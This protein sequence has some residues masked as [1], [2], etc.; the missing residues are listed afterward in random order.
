MGRGLYESEPVFR[1]EVDRCCELLRPHLGL[2]LRELLFPASGERGGGGR[3]AAPDRAHAAGPVR[4]RVR[5]GHASGCSGGSARRRCSATASASTWPPAW[6]ASSR[7]ADA[8]ALVAA[9]GRLMQRLPGGRDARRAA[10]RGRGG[11]A[12]AAASCRSPPS[13]RPSLCVVA[14]PAAAIEA[15]RERLGGAG[16]RRPPAAHLARLPLRDDGPDPGAVRRAGAQGHAC[17]R[18]ALPYLSNVTGTWIRPEEATDPGLL[19]RH[20]R[21]TVRF[22]DGAAEL[23]REPDRVFLEVGPGNALT[24]LARQHPAR[25]PAHAGA[26]VAAPPARGRGRRR[27]SCSTP[28]A[29]SGS[30]APRS[31]GAASTPTSGGGGCRCRPTPSSASATGSSRA[32][33]AGPREGRGRRRRDLAAWF[34]APGWKRTAP[35]AARP[36]RE[37]AGAWLVFLD[38]HGLGAAAG[39]APGGPGAAGDRRAGRGPLRRRRGARLHR[40][41]LERRRLR[42]CCS[43][44]SPPASVR[45]GTVLH[46]WNVTAEGAG[47][48]LPGADR[49]LERGFFSLIFLAQALGRRNLPSRCGSW[50]S[51]PACSA[52]TGEEPLQPHKAALLGPCRVIP[53]EY[54]DLAC[55]SLDVLL[56]RGRGR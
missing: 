8:L 32:K 55:R 47:A 39:R 11:A 7:C 36:P 19:G 35:R 34:Y 48:S 29:G 53:R 10:P 16:D 26:A 22:A 42:R 20:I 44:S 23:L 2:D 4:R 38:D 1:G 6:P 5:A 18:R 43:R 45:P 54:P 13:T 40:R 30:P 9:R 49:A 24:T 3:A 21:G 51:R 14:G 46:L 27:A 12:A 31:T 15:L 37:T 52:V 25:T 33:T 41:R 17:R 56:A 28:S 50:P